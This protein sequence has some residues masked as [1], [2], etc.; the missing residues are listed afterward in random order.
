MPEFQILLVDDSAADA[1]I[2]ENAAKEASA[3]VSIYWVA[4]GQEALEFLT[5]TGRFAAAQPA[6]LV[7]L[8]LH[9]GADDGL[10]ILRAIKSNP[11]MNRQPVLMLSA[12]TSQAEIDLAYSLGANAY[13]RKPVSLDSYIEL[14]RVIVRHWLDLAVAPSRINTRTSGSGSSLDIADT[15]TF[16]DNF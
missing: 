6:R 5:R 2:F 7:I 12:S 8:D 11:D 16:R 13:F 15:R 14:V 10:V 3:R 4:T 1:R 9:L